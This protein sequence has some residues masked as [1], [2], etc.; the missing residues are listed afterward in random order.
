MGAELL[1]AAPQ[2]A[3]GRLANR[4]SVPTP[5]ERRPNESGGVPHHLAFRRE[6]LSNGD[7]KTEMARIYAEIERVTYHLLKAV[8]LPPSCLCGSPEKPDTRLESL[9]QAI[10]GEEWYDRCIALSQEE[11]G[12]LPVSDKIAELLGAFV[13]LYVFNRDVPWQDERVAGVCSGYGDGHDVFFARV[14]SRCGKSEKYVQ[15][16]G[17]ANMRSRF[18]HRRHSEASLL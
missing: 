4:L 1:T 13:Q 12:L 16:L 14:A 10:F 15:F 11:E 3:S 2:A 8:G 6:G 18:Q 5:H 9:Y 7:T 17:F